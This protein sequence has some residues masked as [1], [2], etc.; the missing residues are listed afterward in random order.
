MAVSEQ[1]TRTT[2]SDARQVL[3]KNPERLD[4]SN[5]LGYEGFSSGKHCWDVKMSGLWSA[6]VAFRT[7]SRSF[8]ENFFGIYV[9]NCEGCS[10]L[11][12][13]PDDS[14]LIKKDSFPTNLRVQLDYEKGTLSFFDLDSKTLRYTMK[15][16]LT[17]TVFPYFSDNAKILPAD[18]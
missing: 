4:S 14:M 15:Q 1:L 17:K 2:K 10:W 7:K 8:R 11:H 12:S 6:G 13:N 16:T 3:P 18:F 9:C 5:I